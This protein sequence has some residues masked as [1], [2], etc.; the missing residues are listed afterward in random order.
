MDINF[1]K[2]FELIE[3]VFVNRDL[4]N[5]ILVI[6]VLD[7]VE[8]IQET[9]PIG[10]EEEGEVISR[11]ELSE[12]RENLLLSFLEILNAVAKKEDYSEKTSDISTILTL[13]ININNPEVT[14]FK[15]DI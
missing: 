7:N 10:H 3:S 9:F 15:F 11:V 5:K 4:S 8:E 13:M 12:I 1:Y 2:Q 14:S 6:N